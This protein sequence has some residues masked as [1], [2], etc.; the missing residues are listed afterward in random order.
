MADFFRIGGYCKDEESLD[1]NEMLIECCSNVVHASDR[2]CD[3]DRV[4]IYGLP[5]MALAFD[6]DD[7]F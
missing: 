3:F 7:F 4:L 6:F 1:K 2:D 5:S